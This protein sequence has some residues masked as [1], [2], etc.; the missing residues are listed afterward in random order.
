MSTALLHYAK[1]VFF[2]FF[3]GGG[4]GGGDYPFYNL[5]DAT[6][7]SLGMDLI[8]SHTVYDIYIHYTCNYLPMLGPK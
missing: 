1:K 8:L 4:G 5:D 3:F 2:F 7:G 6:I